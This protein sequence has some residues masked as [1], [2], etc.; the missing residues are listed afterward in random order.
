MHPTL[1]RAFEALSGAGV[2]W[3]LL[4]GWE[5]L[6]RPGEDVDILVARS[7]L[8]RARAQLRAIGYLELPSW[9]RGPHHFFLTYDASHDAWA[10]LDVVDRLAFGPG[11]VH[12]A[13]VEA[14]MLA[15]R[16]TDGSL[17]RL[18]PEDAFW[19]LLL[20]CL[21]DREEIGERRL[22]RLA[23]LANDADRDA[24]LAAWMQRVLPYESADEVLAAARRRDGASL[25]G[26]GR[27]LR[28]AVPSSVGTTVRDTSRRA[29]RRLTKVRRATLERG[30]SIALLG[31]DGA[32]KSTVAGALGERLPWEV[33]SV[34]LGLYGR[35]P[36]G[37]AIP[38]GWIGRM[39]R[40]WRG[41]LIGLAH[42]LRGRIV[43]YDRFGWDALL[44]TT[45]RRGRFAALR[46]WMLAHAIPTPDLVVLLD[47][48]AEVV[49]ARKGEHDVATLQAQRQAYLALADRRPSI[50]VVRADQELDRIL[51][52]IT[53]A[54]WNR[55]LA[56][57]RQPR[58]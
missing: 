16:V 38:G 32:G 29:A 18:A 6:G 57:R 55:V 28:S 22:D 12:E 42:R 23:T 14:P 21:L 2:R 1:A 37:G 30:L 45:R 39:A 40:L 34:Y 49:Y 7:D 35:G 31:V 9:G 50:Q 25:E 36:S 4:R 47:A 8:A 52:T 3:C 51:V 15:R 46:R 13:A 53:A 54:L 11:G 48:P 44:D 33:R 56:T 26:L 41:Y 27:R 19:A 43:I 10:K 17:A 58:R 5:E 20:H 24:P